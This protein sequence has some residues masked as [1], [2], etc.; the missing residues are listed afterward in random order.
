MLWL[1]YTAAT[2]EDIFSTQYAEQWS[3]RK[4][5]RGP[6]VFGSEIQGGIHLGRSNPMD[7]RL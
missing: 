3:Y 4:H 7:R 2:H 6:V 1:V 5:G